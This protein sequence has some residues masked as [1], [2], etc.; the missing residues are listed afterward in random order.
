MIGYAEPAS[1]VCS[2]ISHDY[3]SSFFQTECFKSSTCFLKPCFRR[4]SP[5]YSPK[6][7]IGALKAALPLCT[8]LCSSLHIGIFTYI[9]FPIYISSEYC[10]IFTAIGVHT[11]NHYSS[12]LY[13]KR[14]QGEA[15]LYGKQCV[16]ALFTLPP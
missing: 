11:V 9:Q 1:S 4:N 10:S 16:L 7:M 14:E 12:W 6:S 5:R 8:V 2:R 13:N 15:V 3:C